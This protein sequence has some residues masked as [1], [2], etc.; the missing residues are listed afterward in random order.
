MKIA[1]TGASGYIGR[2]TVALAVDR[3][4]DVVTLARRPL[5]ISGVRHHAYDLTETSPVVPPDTDALIHLAA[6]TAGIRLDEVDAE[7]DAARKLIAACPP[8]CRFVF[9]SSQ[10]ADPKSPS[11]Y[12]L[13]KWKI[14][15]VVAAAGGV[16]V[17]PGLVYGGPEM[18]LFGKLC[19]ALRKLPMYPLFFWPRPIVQPTHVDDLAGVLLQIA[20]APAFEGRLL[21]LAPPDPMPFDRFLA[22]IAR[23][24]LQRHRAPLPVPT[25]LMISVLGLAE[26]ATGRL[27][28]KAQLESLAQTRP[29]DSAADVGRVGMRFRPL[30]KGLALGKSTDRPLVREGT[31][32]IRRFLGTAPVG[33]VKRYVRHVQAH[34]GP[35]ARRARLELALRIAEATPRGARVMHGR[36]PAP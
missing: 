29:H 18:G 21:R 16:S 12:G 15:Q 6:R 10:S 32:F 13:V 20:A 36:P 14:E 22:A 3:R 5:G 2:R 17:R 8:G 7:V 30:A 34:E 4:I 35:L 26:R 25:A 33:T 31:V 9:L 27:V 11:G 23:H 19:G 1:I 24:R 28:G